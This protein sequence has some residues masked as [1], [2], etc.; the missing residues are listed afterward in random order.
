MAVAST[1]EKGTK[2]WDWIC[3]Q[4]Q[5]KNRL[6]KPSFGKTSP[7]KAHDTTSPLSACISRKDT[8]TKPTASVAP[9]CRSCSESPNRRTSSST[10]KSRKLRVIRKPLSPLDKHATRVRRASPGG[11]PL[12]RRRGMLCS[13]N[14][15]NGKTRHKRFTAIRE[16]SLAVRRHLS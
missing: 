4:T 6:K 1:R 2:L 7:T 12:Y 3:T 13:F 5:R 11:C 16:S 8:G 15:P 14:H 9:T 10:S